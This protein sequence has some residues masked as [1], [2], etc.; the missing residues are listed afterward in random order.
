[1]NSIPRDIDASEISPSKNNQALKEFIDTYPTNSIVQLRLESVTNDDM[2]S[3]VQ[4]AIHD[5][6][7]AELWLYHAR[8]TSQGALILSHALYNNSTLKKLYLN[9]NF[10]QDRGIFHL[11]RALAINN[12]KLEELYLA[13]NAITSIG[14]RYLADM[15]VTNRTLKTLSL[16]GN[17][18]DNL[19]IKYFAH[20][21]SYY[22]STLECLQLSGNTLMSDGSIEYLIEMIEYNQTLKKIHLFN[23]NLS[24]EGREKLQTM[25][26]TLKSKLILYA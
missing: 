3:I 5:K 13:R 16:F 24:N 10:I 2:R 18:I 19:G 20:S 26:R 11:A 15:L 6:K 23:C 9:D 1:M 12:S 21:L 17:L 7:S 8:I 22:N 14:A 25:I 4:H